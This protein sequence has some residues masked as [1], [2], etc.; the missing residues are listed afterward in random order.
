MLSEERIDIQ[1]PGEEINYPILIGNG[2]IN[3]LGAILSD[4]YQSDKI[5]LVTDENVNEIYGDKVISNLKEKGYD[6]VRYVVP[7]GEEAKSRHYL[8]K[9]YDL[10][11][12]NNFQRN[13]L[14]LVLGGGV[15]GDLA[16]YLAASY[17]RGIPFIQIPTTLLAQV[18][19]S[20]GGKT[21]INHPSGKN[22]IG[23]FYQPE[24][25]IIDVGLLKTLP[26][27]ELKTGLAEVIKYGF[28][29]DDDFFD[30]LRENKEKV[31][32]LDQ[33]V[34]KHIVKISCKI[35]GGVVRRDQKEKGERAI[36]NF[37]HTIAHALEAITG[38]QLYN[39]GEAVA[40]GMRGA[41]QLSAKLGFLSGDDLKLAEEIL[42]LY[43]L[44]SS[45]SAVQA[46]TEKIYKTMYY[47]KKVKNNR[48]RWILLDKIGS[49]FITD[50]VSKNKII[51]VLEE[52]K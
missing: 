43:Q 12:E 26:I 4:Y 19:S 34:L 6:P 30:F 2:F 37:G 33:A 28:I 52:I 21:A 20:V 29:A 25:V 27:R 9:G 36:L 50:E 3:E 41:L 42:D 15:P 14:I 40:I 49:A 22:L 51:E 5:F 44:P 10:L 1:I 46:E 8:K 23:A 38:Y 48:L 16:G 45:Y 47:D 13:N 35:K 17:M 39:H 11:I 32:D 24:L 7:V 31:F 18:D